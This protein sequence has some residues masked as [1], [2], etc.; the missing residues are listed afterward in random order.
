MKQTEIASLGG[1]ASH[2]G[3]KGVLNEKNL[4]EAVRLNLLTAGVP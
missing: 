4:D 2:K 3:Q 1:K